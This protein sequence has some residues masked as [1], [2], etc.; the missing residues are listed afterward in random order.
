MTKVAASTEMITFGG[1][2]QIA[3]ASE[4]SGNFQIWTMNTDGTGQRQ[5]TGW[6]MVPVNLLVS[7]WQSNCIYISM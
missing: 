7:R 5:I 2:S 4:R 3:F 1:S 6:P